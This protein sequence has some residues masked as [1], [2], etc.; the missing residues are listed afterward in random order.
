MSSGEKGE[1]LAAWREVLEMPEIRMEP[2][3]QYEE[4]VRLADNYQR[5]GLISEEE[6]NALIFEATNRYAS[7][8]AGTR[9]NE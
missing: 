9:Y 6:K 7:L 8:V 5:G 3:A 1:A 2:A 4:L